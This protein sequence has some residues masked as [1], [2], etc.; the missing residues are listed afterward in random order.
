MI[1]FYIISS[2]GTLI[3][4]SS[5][6]DINTTI[7]LTSTLHSL[8]NMSQSVFRENQFQYIILEK[9]IISLFK[10]L[11]GAIFAVIARRKVRFDIFREIYTHYTQYVVMNPCYRD[12]MVIRFAAFRPLDIL[13]KY[14]FV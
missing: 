8:L 14:G 4:H 10:T 2:S 6:M 5:T 3:Y 1:S 11:R 7:I 13:N 12:G 9:T